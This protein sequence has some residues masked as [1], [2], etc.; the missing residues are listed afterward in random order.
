MTANLRELHCEH[1]STSEAGGEYFQVMF[2]TIQDSD[3][4][5]LLVQRQFEMRDGGE[6]YVETDDLKFCGHFR[7]RNARLTSKQFQFEFGNGPA[8]KISVSFEVTESVFAEIKRVLQIIIP[9]LEFGRAEGL[10]E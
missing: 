10:P 6:C 3:E 1:V 5:Y 9:D 2:A 8:R 4:G 7:L